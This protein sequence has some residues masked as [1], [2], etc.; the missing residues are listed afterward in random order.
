MKFIHVSDLHYHRDQRD[1]ADADNLLKSLHDKYP[2]HMLI[3]TG[4]V[5]D[6][7]HRIQYANA[8]EA[9][10]PFKGRVF[11]APG[12]HDFGA[13]GNFYSRE[14]AVLF[15]ALLMTPLAQAGTFTGDNTPVVNVLGDGESSV[16]LIA[17]DTNLETN[18][19]FDFA[20]GAVGCGQLDALNTILGD[21]ACT[22]R[23]KIVFFHHHPFMHGNPFMELQDCRELMRSLYMRAD[24]VLFGHKHVSK[25]W[26]NVN[27]IRFVLASD[28]SPGKAWV[29]EITVEQGSI[30]VQD[31]PTR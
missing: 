26:E 8:L 27:G 9:L 29:R 5:T 24:V 31:V 23:T 2:D 22:G 10:E 18:D 19:P 11:I 3:V 16:M 28:N 12:N 7:G 13:A 6:D 21:S 15:D 25:E 30:T 20:C 4:D 14:R 1:N 17:L